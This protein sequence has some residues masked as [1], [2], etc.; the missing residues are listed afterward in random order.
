MEMVRC[1]LPEKELPKEYWAEATIVVFLLNR[2]PTKVVD[3][4]TPFEAWYD[5]KPQLKNLKVFGCLCFTNVPQVKRDKLDKRVKPNIFIKYSLT[6]KAYRIFQPDTRKILI[7]RDVSFMEN[8]KW[9]WNDEKK[10]AN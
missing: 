7:S 1:M 8:E 6:S 5:F 10:S 9:S 4:N 3:G 2:L